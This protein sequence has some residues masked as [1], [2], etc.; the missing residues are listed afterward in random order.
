V[1]EAVSAVRA[2]VFDLFG[3]LV[4]EFPLRAWERMFEGMASALGADLACFRREWGAT[5][6]ERQTGGFR[7]V[8][9]NVRTICERL[10][11]APAD[12]RV[13]EALEVRD[14][15]YAERF[16]P[17]PD[18]I[19][20]LSWLRERG[21]ATALVSM[22][23]PDAPAFWQASPLAG[24]IDVLVFSCEVGL[25]KPD[26]AIYLAASGRLGV[27]PSECVYVGDGSNRELSGAAAVGMR[28]VRIVDPAEEGE[29]LRP[30]VD[31]WSG[32]EIR[33]LAAIR[34]VLEVAERA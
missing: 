1:A 8:E 31:D 22:C 12:A 16:H 20:T 34:H 17:Q 14:A 5:I 3:T 27:D 24:S 23:A 11:L 25:R 7:T 33:S 21:Y 30:D 18:A 10:A 29:M 6:V 13:A 4:P 9:E 26:P 28:P 2:V 19:E 32:A 15:L